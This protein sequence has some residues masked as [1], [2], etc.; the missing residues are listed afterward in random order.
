MLLGLQMNTEIHM[1]W[2]A[3]AAVQSRMMSSLQGLPAALRLL[4]E[5]H[6]GNAA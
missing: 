6:R 1:S 2:G 5:L 3:E 4:Q